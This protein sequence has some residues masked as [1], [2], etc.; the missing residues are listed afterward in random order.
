L[1][2]QHP[3]LHNR[4]EEL[5]TDVGRLGRYIDPESSGHWILERVRGHIEAVT[6]MLEPTA[7]EIARW[8][9][10]GCDQAVDEAIRIVD[11]RYRSLQHR[12][13]GAA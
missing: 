2:Q 9:A 4:I 5:A 6:L 7:A 13:R 3:A 12:L 1:R 10:P 8:H 11:A